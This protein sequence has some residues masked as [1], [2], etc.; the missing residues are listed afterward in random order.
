M[1]GNTS[2]MRIRHIFPI[3][4]VLAGCLPGARAAA[5]T[6]L[7]PFTA[8]YQVQRNGSVIGQST[9]T[10]SRDA[11]GNW[12]YAS[13]LHGT[14]GLAALLG[15]SVKETSTFRWNN[16][17]PEALAYD[18]SLDATVKSKHRHLD[19]NWAGHKVRVTENGKTDTYAP[20]PGLVERHTVPLALALEVEDGKTRMALPVAVRDRV[21][22][23]Q[24]KVTGTDQVSVPAGHFDAKKVQRTDKQ[25][26]FTAWYA[27]Q[28]PLA[29]VKLAQSSGGHISMR[30]ESYKAQ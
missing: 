7:H 8:T 17:Q 29:P 21:Q 11:R 6:T 12:R 3:L 5:A 9:L 19:V 16:H 1:T 18:Y 14:H 2:A 22:T 30:L 26:S 23:Q 4:A 27:P 20:A 15:A 10:L 28:H 24:F 13:H 25:N